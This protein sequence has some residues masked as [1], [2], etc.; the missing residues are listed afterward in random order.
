MSL[1]RVLRGDDDDDCDAAC[2]PACVALPAL[3]LLLLLGSG[4]DE[5]DNADA[6]ALA[7]PG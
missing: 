2:T 7:P 5:V 4:A 6:D 3:L 1:T